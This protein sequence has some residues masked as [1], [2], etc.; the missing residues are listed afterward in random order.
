MEPC[1][2]PH[3]D[4]FTIIELLVVLAAVALLLG[5]AAPRYTQHLDKARDVALRHNLHQLRDAIDKFH[6][7]QARYPASLDELVA[8]RYLRQVPLD[9]VTDRVDTWVLVPPA[10]STAGAVF[11]VRS[12]AA[13]RASD[14]SAY[15]AW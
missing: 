1:C 4:G 2:H 6:A 9:P 14:G 11:D 10:A 7:D 3:R 12:G 8:R 13:G 15:A 5:V